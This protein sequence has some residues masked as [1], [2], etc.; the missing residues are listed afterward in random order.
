MNVRLG[1]SSRL[2][3][4]VGCKQI[5]ADANRVLRCG[6]CRGR[7]VNFRDVGGRIDEGGNRQ[8][9]ARE[10]RLVHSLA[11]P[12]ASREMGAALG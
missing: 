4:S 12:F 1:L 10:A 5:V 6:V 9:A 2:R 3:L 11:D 8:Q 7:C